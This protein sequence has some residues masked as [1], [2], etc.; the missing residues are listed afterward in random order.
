MKP[1]PGAPPSIGNVSDNPVGATLDILSNHISQIGKNS[2][3]IK[4]L[5]TKVD[6]LVDVT[7]SCPHCRKKLEG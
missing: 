3:G 1:T 4:E 2:G 6:K 7:K 5:A